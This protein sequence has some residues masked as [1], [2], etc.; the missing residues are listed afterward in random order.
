MGQLYVEQQGVGQLYVEQ[1]G[2][3][4]LCVEQQGVGQLCVEQQGVGQLYVELCV[5]TGFPQV[6]KKLKSEK[7]RKF[8]YVSGN[9][10]I[11]QKVRKREK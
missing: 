11:H 2:V 6:R 1:Q 8:C 5:K 4:Q 9:F 3:G 7:V 10:E